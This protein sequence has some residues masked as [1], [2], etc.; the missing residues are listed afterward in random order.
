M[1]RLL[2]KGHFGRV[3]RHLR[4]LLAVLL[5]R[6]F[7]NGA[8]QQSYSAYPVAGEEGYLLGEGL[9]S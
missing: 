6:R 4:E 2:L 9:C 7:E 5:G 3:A 8:A 1:G